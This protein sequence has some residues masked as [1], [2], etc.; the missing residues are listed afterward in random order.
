M[1][2]RKLWGPGLAGREYL[3]TTG[4][5]VAAREKPRGACVKNIR[6]FRMSLAAKV[7]V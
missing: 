5:A 2:L 6:A 7:T 3:A 4:I 1:L